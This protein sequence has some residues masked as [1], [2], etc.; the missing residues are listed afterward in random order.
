M[1]HPN[2]LAELTV[3]RP[4][5]TDIAREAGVSKS[6]VSKVARG[7][8]KATTGVRAAAEKLLGVPAEVIFPD[9]PAA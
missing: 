3:D 5:L 9:E 4:T 6:F 7:H 8:R 1:D 2:R